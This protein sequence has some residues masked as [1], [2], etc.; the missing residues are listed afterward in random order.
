MTQ[1]TTM[2]MFDQQV[3]TARDWFASPRFDGIVRLYSP[4]QV[5]EQ[6][7]T[8]SG[9]YT[10]A[11]QSAAAFYARL[12]ELFDERRQMTTF[13]PY[14]PGQAVMMKRVGMEGIYLGGWATSARGSI[15]EDP[16]SE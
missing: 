2:T 7:G 4:R 9:D 11:R 3:A 1:E 10:V 8:L 14:S 13:G 16:R 15:A 6:Q 5:A 12:R